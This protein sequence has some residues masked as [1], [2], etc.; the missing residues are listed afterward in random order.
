MFFLK[1]IFKTTQ[2]LLNPNAIIRNA[3]SPALKHTKKDDLQVL[4]CIFTFCPALLPTST[5]VCPL[6]RRPK[7]KEAAQS[8]STPPITSSHPKTQLS[9]VSPIRRCFSASFSP[10]THPRTELPSEYRTSPMQQLALI[11]LRLLFHCISF[12]DSFHCLLFD[13]AYLFVL[14]IQQKLWYALM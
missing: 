7:Y 1:C 4:V 12:Q 14:Y 3:W 8:G 5:A 11:Q 9:A 13:L 2:L 10:S 6:S